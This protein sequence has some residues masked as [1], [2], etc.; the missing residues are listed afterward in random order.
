MKNV[1]TTIKGTKLTIEV[2]LEKDFGKSASGK[3]T[4]I[5]TSSG[6]QEIADNVY[7]GLNIYKKG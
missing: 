3:T 2:D 5:A 6:N 7:L 4:I 1:T